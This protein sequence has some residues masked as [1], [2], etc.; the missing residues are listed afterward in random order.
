MNYRKACEV[1]G[2]QEELKNDISIELLKKQYRLKALIYHPDKNPAEDA[3]LKFQEIHESYEYLMKYKDF[4]EDDEEVT[5]DKNDYKN[6]LFSFIRNIIDKDSRNTLFY[7]ILKKVSTTCEETALDT[8]NK[9]D[10]NLLIKI[11]EIAS[12]YK[13]AF[14]FAEDFIEKIQVI[15]SEKVKGD[16]CIILNPTL[17][18]LFDDNLYKLKVN[19]FTYIVP[20]WH[21]ELVY[22]NSGND[23]YVKCNPILP[24]NLEIDDKNN[25]IVSV[26]KQIS[27][28]WGKEYLTINVEK[29]QFYLK[30][31]KIKLKEEQ[32]FI[33]AEEGITKINTT[34]VYDVSVKSDVYVKLH[35]FCE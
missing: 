13:D 14:H 30:V 15:I 22:D 10:K 8:L 32:L 28:I 21:H 4:I 27:E 24:D 6:V 34:N 23:I 16:E 1:L 5:W 35:L 7:T 11:Y 19:G 25:I 20:L 26:E 18:D 33:F 3:C 2:I 29:K 9:L 17:D 31:D 12:K